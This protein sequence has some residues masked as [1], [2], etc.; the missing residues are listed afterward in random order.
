ME[1]LNLLKGSCTIKCM[2]FQ[3]ENAANHLFVFKNPG[4]PGF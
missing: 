3:C 1:M 2:S 4:R